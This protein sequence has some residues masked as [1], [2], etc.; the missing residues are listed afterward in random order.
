MESLVT[1]GFPRIFFPNAAEYPPRY[2]YR[3]L[4][5]FR[6]FQRKG[7]APLYPRT[8]YPVRKII[9]TGI[10]NKPNVQL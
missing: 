8:P 10:A 9:T 2:L 3:N 5:R 4:A 6:D 1:E 7:R